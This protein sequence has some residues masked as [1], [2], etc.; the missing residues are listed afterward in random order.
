MAKVTIENLAGMMK[1]SFDHLEEKIDGVKEELK[2]ELVEVN[3]R[4]DRIESK[5][6][7]NHENRIS[8]LEDDVRIIKTA[9]EK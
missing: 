6:D 7:N 4:L 1:T 5:V 2:K 9:L 8:R 3:L